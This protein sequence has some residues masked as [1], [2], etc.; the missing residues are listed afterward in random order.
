MYNE[1]FF[2]NLLPIIIHKFHGNYQ[3]QLLPRA[4]A[5]SS[6][7]FAIPHFHLP[8]QQRQIYPSILISLFKPIS[9]RL[10]KQCRV[11][12]DGSIGLV[13]NGEIGKIRRSKEMIYYKF[14]VGVVRFKIPVCFECKL[15]KKMIRVNS[16]I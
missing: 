9:I 5:M 13:R 15:R 4:S 12:N 7:I 1:A 14:R 8:K 10:M 2:H 3:L 16:I 11:E 6:A